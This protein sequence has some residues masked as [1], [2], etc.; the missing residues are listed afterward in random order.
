MTASERTGGPRPSKFGLGSR[1]DLRESAVDYLTERIQSGDWPVGQ[2]IPTESEL[3]AEA[4]ISRN[5]IREAVSSLVHT[6]L[7]E[8][9]QGSGTFV[10]SQSELTGLFERHL[11][12]KDRQD[13]LEIRLALEVV[14]AALAAT[15]RTDEDIEGLLASMTARRE[16]AD[17]N[18]VDGYVEADLQLHRQFVRAA[19]NPLLIE[20]YDS[21]L[22]GFRETIAS[23][24]IETGDPCHEEHEALVHAI[25]AGDPLNAAIELRVFLDSHLYHV[26]STAWPRVHQEVGSR[27]V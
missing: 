15:R 14:A 9:R 12:S 19:Q 18:D 5:T 17:R 10:V 27:E 3:A 11:S 23:Y 21:M 1:T 7:L 22:E 26:E 2:Q 16:T 13:V 24:F 8:R 20:L 6:G 4:G 25:I